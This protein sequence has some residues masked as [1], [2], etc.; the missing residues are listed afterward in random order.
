MKQIA[1]ETVA[2]LEKLYE[3]Q[4]FPSPVRADIVWVGSRLGAFTSVGPPPHA[5]ISSGD[6]SGG[7]WAEVETVFHEFSH[8]LIL[9]IQ[10]RIARSLGDRIREH[11]VLWHVVQFYLTGAAVQEVL[12]GRGIDHEPYMYATGLFDR[13]WGRY[14]RP[15]ETNWEPYLQGKVNLD[16]AI[17]GTLKMLDAAR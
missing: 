8:V 10:A 2:R 12:K 7:G 15:V 11:G 3:A 14:R 9:P 6:M 1:P 4:W 16:D 17:A 13:A 5:T